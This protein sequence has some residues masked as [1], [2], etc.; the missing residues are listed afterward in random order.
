MTV[1]QFTA[2]AREGEKKGVYGDGKPI[3]LAFSQVVMNHPVRI[4]MVQTFKANCKKYSNVS[5][6][7]TEGNG[8]P[9]VEIANIESL[10]QRKPDVL[11]VSSLSGTAV[12]PA[13]EEVNSAKIPL[14]I[15]NSGI[16]DDSAKNIKYTSFISPDDWQNG[17][18]LGQYMADRLHGK[19]SV[20]VIEGVAESSNYEHRLG[21]FM[22]VVNKYPDIHIVG[23]QSGAWIRMPAMK[24]AVDLLQA[25]PKIDGIYAMNDEMGMGVLSA[26]RS[27]G[28]EQDVVMV[29]VDGQKD[30][31]QEILKGS[32]A[33]ATV[34]WE[35]DMTR[36][37]DAALAVAEGGVI[38]P[39]VWYKEPLITKATAQEV[40]DKRLK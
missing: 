5:C 10:V 21:G 22:E 16:P 36:V 28:R 33:E 14:I 3:K 40:L 30:L 39:R 6:I 20:I 35:S 26:L 12:Y 25:N 37:V 9:S 13:Y 32:A 38:D 27:A 29:S 19:G 1:E 15:N 17:R 4:N 24:A 7:V 31:V 2:K 18:L 11:I 34:Y 23:K 8:E